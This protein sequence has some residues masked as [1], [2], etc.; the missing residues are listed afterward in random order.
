MLIAVML[1][2][3]IASSA[4][5][6]L[7]PEQKLEQAQ[8]QLEAAQKAVEQARKDAKKASDKTESAKTESK[9]SSE[10]WAIP[11]EKKIDE[12]V[13]RQ[14]AKIEKDTEDA[15]YLAG[16]VPMA[17]NNVVFTL[18]KDFPGKSSDEIYDDVYTKIEN[19]TRDANQ[20]ENSRIALVNKK[21]HTIAAKMN[22][23]LV[24]NNSF[25]SLDR[26][27]FSYALIAQITGSHLHVTISRINYSYEADRSTGFKSSAEDLISD[28][29]A[30]T[31]KGKLN[32]MSAKFRKKTI[33]RKNEIFN[34]LGK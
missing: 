34:I 31:K 15:Q 9:N 8:K 1:A 7:T 23:W 28:K 4:Q 33:D 5:E 18:D 25:I 11:E 27:E 12:N 10:G 3:P 19:I 21:D 32:K 22:E 17:D 2:M 20:H 29:A 16:A 6:V 14:Q 26:S 24:F 30:L 13:V